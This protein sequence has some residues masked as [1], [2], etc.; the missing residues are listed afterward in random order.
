M[1]FLGGAAWPYG[2]SSTI[3]YEKFFFAGGSNSIRAWPPRRLGPGSYDH[4]DDSGNVS[5]R[6]EQPGNIILEGSV[7]Y[8]FKIWWIINGALFV[9][10][11]NVWTLSEDTDRP[12]G[13]FTNEFWREVAVGTGFGLRFDFTFLLLRLDLGIKAVDPAQPQGSRWVLNN[14]SINKPFSG[15]NAALLNIG[16]GYPF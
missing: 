7:E 10:M 1:R 9:D 15:S 12:G 11:G 4:I 16:I 14:I 8:R 2:N 13:Q 3:P 5:Y 6:F